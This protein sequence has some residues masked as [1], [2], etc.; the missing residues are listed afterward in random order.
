MTEAIEKS[1]RRTYQVQESLANRRFQISD[2]FHLY[3]VL[4]TAVFGFT[5][6]R[7]LCTCGNNLQLLHQEIQIHI[8]MRHGCNGI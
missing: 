8:C 5:Y 1:V 3:S 7:F 2:A 6:P 4:P